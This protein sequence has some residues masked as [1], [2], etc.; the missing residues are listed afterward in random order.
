VSLAASLRSMPVLIVGSVTTTDRP[1]DSLASSGSPVVYDLSPGDHPA[2]GSSVFSASASTAAQTQAFVNFA[3][4]KGWKRVGVITSTDASGQD[5]WEN[6]EKA[7]SATGG[8]VSVTDHETFA[9]TDVSVTS[10]ISRI[11]SSHPQALFIWTTGTPLG[12]VLHGM[13]QA[14]FTS[15]P[16]MTTNGNASYAEMQKLAAILPAQLYFPG[17][18][19][20]LDPSTLPNPEKQLVATFQSA[21]R[22]HGSVVPDEGNALAWDPGLILVSTLKKLGVHATASQVHSYIEGLS[23]FTGVDGTYDFKSSAVAPDNRGIG[24]SSVIITQWNKAKRR[25]VQASGPAGKSLKSP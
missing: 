22:S 6:I 1:V 8:A 10:Q 25:W 3:Q 7:V 2:R 15:V 9:P 11:E 16:V 19:F 5:G 18:A 21:M 20:Q 17:A 13:Q 24:V 23:A 4:A 14:G 12:T